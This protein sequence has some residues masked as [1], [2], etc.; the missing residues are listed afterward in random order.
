M[1]FGGNVKNS[2]LRWK[3]RGKMI[4]DFSTRE[5]GHMFPERNSVAAFFHT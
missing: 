2:G 1:P 3:R 4:R 5:N